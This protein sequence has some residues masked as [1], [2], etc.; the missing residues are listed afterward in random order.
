MA[1]IKKAVFAGSFAPVHLGHI[2]IL[3]QACTLFDEV[4]LLLA[5]NA[6]KEQM[7]FSA[8]FRLEML[9]QAIKE[10]VNCKVI[11]LD[12]LVATYMQQEKIEYAIRGVRNINDFCY[13]QT[14]ALANS[15]LNKRCKTLLFMTEQSLTHISST[16][17]RECLRYGQS[18]D[19][20]VP[21]GVAELLK[22]YPNGK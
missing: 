5:T 1:T 4:H 11:C 10:F 3:Q 19:A 22:K 17:I 20:F 21:K 2:S 13:E 15:T 9:Q 18:I 14:M 12:G 16:L 8:A 6:A 7:P